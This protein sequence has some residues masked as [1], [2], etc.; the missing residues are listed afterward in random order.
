M[1]AMGGNW[2]PLEA[3]DGHAVCVP[4]ACPPPEPTPVQS[5]GTF[6]RTEA[7]SYCPEPGQSMDGLHQVSLGE[8]PA[9]I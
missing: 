1:M 3:N 6:T 9:G 7:G 5:S 2:C 4:R 8:R